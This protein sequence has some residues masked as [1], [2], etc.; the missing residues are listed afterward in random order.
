MSYCD[1]SRCEQLLIDYHD[2]EWGVPLFDDIKQFEFLMME[3]MQCGL[4]W[5]IVMKKREIFRNCFDRFDFR[6]VALYDEQDVER[7]LNTSG[8]IRSAPKIRA[9]INNAK[10]F[11][12]ICEEFGSFCRYLWS[13]SDNKTILYEG[14]GDGFIPT[15]NG[16]S[17][18][19]SRDL[20]KRG[21]KYLGSVTVYSHLQS[22]GIINDHGSD[23]PCYRRINE[24]NQTIVLPP[25]REQNVKKH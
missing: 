11:V 17:D 13:F 15:A 22:C 2:T 12:K 21:F 9:V 4:S 23:C 3:A 5:T 7:I 6:K 10:C 18:D 24:S 19:I 8:M 20:K 16:L 14:H 25:D 1:W